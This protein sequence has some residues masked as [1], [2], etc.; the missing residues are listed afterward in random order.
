MTECTVC[1]EPFNNRTKKIECNF[2]KF[3]VCSGCFETYQKENSGLYD[4][5]CMKCKQI[6]DDEFLHDHVPKVVLSRLRE[7]TK[8]RLRD[9]EQ[10]F[11][12]ETLLYIQYEKALETQLVPEYRETSETLAK[13]QS[14]IR[15]ITQDKLFCS[16]KKEKQ[17][18]TKQIEN[19]RRTEFNAK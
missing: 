4:V 8:Q 12:P 14:D 3:L 16:N 17:D 5:H 7:V 19:L 10:S 11:M 9:E 2:C 1:C 13:T 15:I 18:L 6:W